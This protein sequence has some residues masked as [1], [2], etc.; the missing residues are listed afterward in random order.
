MTKVYAEKA[1]IEAKMKEKVAEIVREKEREI[2]QEKR[3][4]SSFKKKIGR[5]SQRIS[6]G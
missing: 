4:L 2:Y 6:L 1:E 5:P 3:R